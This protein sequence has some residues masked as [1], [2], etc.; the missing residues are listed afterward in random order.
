MVSS[1]SRLAQPGAGLDRAIFWA[2]PMW[3]LGLNEVITGTSFAAM[4]PLA[5]RAIAGLA[6]AALIALVSFPIAAHRTMAAA[7]EGNLS[8]RKGG[9][10][11]VSRWLSRA[12]AFTPE[13]RGALQ[14]TM[15]AL[16]RTHQQ[17][18]IIAVTIGV[19]V[20][21]VTPAAVMFFDGSN[22][23]AWRDAGWG[24]YP[25]APVS[26]LAAPLLWNFVTVL[27]LRAAMAFPSEFPASW[28]FAVAPTPM[29]VGRNAA[30]SLLI[31]IG[32]VLPAL[33]AAPVWYSVW[34]WYYV[35]PSLIAC[36]LGMFTVV[37]AALWGFVGIPCTKPLATGRSGLTSRWP[38]L[39]ICLYFYT[40]VFSHWQLNATKRPG[41]WFMLIPPVLIFAAVHF[42]S[43]SAARANGLSGDPHGY[44]K[45]DLSV[46][47]KQLQ[48]SA[49]NA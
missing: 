49:P 36:L 6:I 48:R 32:V 34:P 23:T 8:S 43:K 20:A 45:L 5:D 38:G 22:L 17:R 41:W 24:L 15:A 42:G 29:F 16:A 46:T 39:L 30:R 18:L 40:N 28:L 12:L 7:V 4:P 11:V 37:D 19:A 1:A 31:I 27:G 10:S 25:A 13:R 35:T 26:L 3:F 44:L 9:L 47:V 14:F 33:V 21:M 2:P